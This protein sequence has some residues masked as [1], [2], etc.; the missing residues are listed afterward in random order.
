MALLDGVTLFLM[1]VV[2]YVWYF[3]QKKY[4]FWTNS[5]YPY[6]KP[7]F[8]YGSLKGSMEKIHLSHLLQKYYNEMKGKGPFGG[9]YLA[10][11]PGVLALDLDFVKQI[12]IRD[13]NFFQ[14]RGM[15]YNEKDDPL[16]A[17]LIAL[18]GAH[19]KPLR[20]HLTPTFTSGKMR[21]M[22]PQI[23]T[24]GERLSDCW[25]SLVTDEKD[26]EIMEYLARYTTD[27]IGTTAFGIECNS[28]KH[29]D[30]DF[31][32]MCRS[33][34][35]DPRHSMKVIFLM[36]A[37][38]ET[39][40]FL[41]MKT[42]K[43][44]VLDFFLGIVKETIEY[45]EKNKVDRND[46]MDILLKMKNKS[47]DGYTLTFNE[48]AAQV[49]VFFAAGFETS[50]ALMSFCLYELAL[51]PEIQDK[52]RAEIRK[53]IHNQ[54]GEFNYDAMADMTYMDCVMNGKYL[55]HR[56]SFIDWKLL[57]AETLR[58]HSP[59]GMLLRRATRDYKVPD[60]GFVIPRDTKLWIPI[61]AIHHDPEYYPD[62]E[63][64]DPN[65]F[66]PEE[67]KKR[68]PLAFL[69]FGNGPRNCIGLKFGMMQSRVGLVEILRNFEISPCDK[70]KCEI[71]KNEFVMTPEDGLWLRVRKLNNNEECC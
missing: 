43:E 49:F 3:L 31:R 59:V 18:D 53:A 22:F 12:L 25:S 63:K 39:A 35:K 64:F 38:M 67:V 5:G 24:V 57:F 16:S 4:N 71:A 7:T 26:V 68:H 51:N 34:F 48:I 9:L 27:V 62:P 33:V 17:H 61:T 1:V 14:E 56:D 20:T 6:I 58:K 30:A 50:A 29:E 47:K 69:P 37:F 40:R 23:R 60:T 8:P 42:H 44:Q 11:R 45:R 2:V 55:V 41:G 70:T 28:L 66:T 54:G 46:F 13:F 36:G 15:Y 52:C 10:Y 32:V 19:W 21:Y 65:R